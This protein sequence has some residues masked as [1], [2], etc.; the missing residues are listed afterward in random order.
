[1]VVKK[2]VGA[3]ECGFYFRMLI[4]KLPPEILCLLAQNAQDVGLWCWNTGRKQGMRSVG[5][6]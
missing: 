5:E 6:N 2:L 4:I 1:M 3:R